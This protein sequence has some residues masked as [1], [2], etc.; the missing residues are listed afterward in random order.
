MYLFIYLFIFQCK[1]YPEDPLYNGGILKDNVEG[2]FGN[3]LMETV[4]YSPAFLLENLTA[5]TRYTF[6]CK[7][8]SILSFL[9]LFIYR[10]YLSVWFNE[11]FEVLISCNLDFNSNSTFDFLLIVLNTF[12]KKLLKTFPFFLNRCLF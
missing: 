7:F 8:L 5:T 10:Y 3:H 6:S 12:I 2:N 4:S 1:S 9:Y 11:E